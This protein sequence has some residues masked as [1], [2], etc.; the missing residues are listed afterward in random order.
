MSDRRTR[1]QLDDH[2]KHRS[3]ISTASLSPAFDFRATSGDF[4]FN[5]HLRSLKNGCK[6]RYTGKGRDYSTSCSFAKGVGADHTLGTVPH[7]CLNSQQQRKPAVIAK[8]VLPQLSEKGKKM[9]ICQ[10]SPAWGYAGIQQ[11]RAGTAGTASHVGDRGLSKDITEV[12]T[13]CCSEAFHPRSQRGEE[14]VKLC[15]ADP[16]S[17]SPSLGCPT[18]TG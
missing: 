6:V 10:P 14:L 11:L 7:W 16:R 13:S 15:L 2:I 17:C 8:Q 4:Y 9:V 3:S 1:Q 18:F 12:R 5:Q